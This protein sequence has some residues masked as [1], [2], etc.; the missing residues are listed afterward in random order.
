M[1]TT[2]GKIAASALFILGSGM[3]FLAIDTLNGGGPS[4]PPHVRPPDPWGLLTEA[5]Y[6]LAYAFI[7]G[8]LCEISTRVGKD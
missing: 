7:L 6:M 5:A 4:V 2:L 8:V 3:A 1:F